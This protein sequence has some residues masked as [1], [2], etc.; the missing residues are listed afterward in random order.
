[1]AVSRGIEPR[2][3]FYGLYTLAVCCITG[4]P[5]HPNK[6]SLIEMQDARIRTRNITK[7]GQIGGCQLRGI[8][9]FRLLSYF[10]Y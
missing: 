10:V 2:Q 9:I 1:M 8:L 4:L 6:M 5:T 3:P 7:N